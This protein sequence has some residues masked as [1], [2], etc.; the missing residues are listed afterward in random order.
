MS[1]KGLAQLKLRLDLALILN[2]L[3]DEMVSVDVM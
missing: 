1:M 2:K 3:E